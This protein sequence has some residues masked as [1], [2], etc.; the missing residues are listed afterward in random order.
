MGLGRTT[1]PSPNWR[2]A[3]KVFN[4]LFCPVSRIQSLLVLYDLRSSQQIVNHV[5]T[6]MSSLVEPVLSTAKSKCI[7]LYCSLSRKIKRVSTKCRPQQD[8]STRTKYEIQSK[9]LW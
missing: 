5:D 1:F 6:L 7:M 2:I 8:F 3:L 4:H 9:C